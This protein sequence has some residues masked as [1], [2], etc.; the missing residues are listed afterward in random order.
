MTLAQVR[1]AAAELLDGVDGD[2]TGTDAE[3]FT[4]LTRRAEELRRDAA[5]T[6]AD[7]LEGVRSG[8]YRVESAGVSMHDGPRADADRNPAT[9]QRDTAMRT[10]ERAVKDGTLAAGGAETIEAAITTG[11]PA[12]RSWAA[13]WA[14]TTADPDYLQAFAKVVADPQR[15]HM[16][17]T[18]RE[19]AVFRAAAE[20]QVEQRAMSLTDNAG[21][22][23]IPAQLDPSILLAS[24]GS[25]NPLRQIARVVQ[26]TADT[27]N[28]VSSAGV[29][30]EWLGEGSEAADAA[31]TLAGPSIPLYKGAAWVP[32]SYEV[33]QDAANFV[34][35]IGKLLM[36][37]VEQL[38]AAAYCTGSG[39][40]QPTGFITALA[41]SDPTVIVTGDG[42]EA[43]AASDAYKLQ[44][45]LPP[46]FQANSA[47]VAALPVINTFRQLETGSGALKFPGLMTVPPSLLGRPIYEVSNMDSSINAA[48]TAANYV[49]AV[50][51]WSNFVISDKIGTVVELVPHVFGA[52]RRPTGQRGFFAHFRTGSDVVVD[53]A[54]RLLN[55]PTTE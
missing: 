14:A 26:T 24:N 41:A 17:F 16:L 35:E 48:A 55:V 37:S 36:D 51:D 45:A 10:V 30:A 3:R 11:A 15:G 23:L 44:N 46:R 2:L 1:T 4:A 27:W 43:I 28:G 19:A 7:V 5:A 34:A 13:R 6:R 12:S 8:R 33:E 52:N 9:R 22:Y 47:F 38:S 25:T 49:L 40:G 39:N 54:F 32:F 20:L 50:G 21:G 29:T 53:N 42:S 18:E 31:P